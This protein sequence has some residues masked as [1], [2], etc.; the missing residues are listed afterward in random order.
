MEEIIKLIIL[1]IGG[2]LAGLYGSNVG[3]GALVTFP[4]MILSGLPTQIAIATNRMGAVFL[5]FS[6]ALKFFKEKKVKVKLGLVFG[7]FAAA[8]S[9][10]G[11]NIVIQVNEKY[12][13][14]IIA[15]VFFVLFLI[16]YNKKKIGIQENELSQK[17]LIK[18]GIFIFLLGIYGGFFGGGFGTFIMFLLVLSGFTFIKSAGLGR[19][20][21]FIMSLTATIVFA[22]NGM[23]DYPYAISVGLGSAVGAWVGVSIG[24][25]KGNK[26]IKTLFIIIVFITIIKLLMKFF[27]INIL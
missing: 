6:S 4:L 12:L 27:G 22:I 19:V 23:I 15:I 24:I 3:S 25:K 26:F 9:F 2:I 8:G 13:N 14:L 20:I 21:G 7:A 16:M 10:I 18:T 17:K 5:E 1:F 11:S